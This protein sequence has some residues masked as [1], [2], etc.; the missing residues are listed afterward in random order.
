M[1]NWKKLQKALIE[2]R[3]EREWEQFHNPKDLA[4]ALSIEAAELNELF[5]WKKPED[6]DHEKV[7][8]ELADVLAYALLL[9]QKYDLNISQI[10][11][12]KIAKNAEK[13]PIDKAKGSAKKYNEL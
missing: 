12:N 13:Y 11:L 3:N 4:L 1:E 7:A 6:A 9:A 10:V 2:F 8:D 5:L